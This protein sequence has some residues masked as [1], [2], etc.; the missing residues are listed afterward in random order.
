MPE[1]TKNIIAIVL[2]AVAL[3][4]IV[5]G[6]ASGDRSEPTAEERVASLSGQIKC[7][8]CNGESLAD[9]ASG[10]AG[11][12]RI[13]I[14]DLVADGYTDDE[15]LDEFAENFGESYVLDSGRL[16]WSAALWA[17]PVGVLIGG[18]VVLG[19]MRRSSRTRD[20]ADA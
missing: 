20:G 15:I 19:S 1:K 7:P 18:A 12:Y 17:V 5:A 2:G 8:F 9:S 6:L 10:V 13:L 4:V 16:R 11:D 3:V 14:A